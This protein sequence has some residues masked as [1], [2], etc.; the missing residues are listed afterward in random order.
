M[1]RVHEGVKKTKWV[2]RNAG[3]DAKKLVEALGVNEMRRF[4]NRN[5]GDV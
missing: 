5:N 3:W 2:L 1:T 4:Q